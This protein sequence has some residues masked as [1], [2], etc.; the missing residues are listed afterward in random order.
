MARHTDRSVRSSKANNRRRVARSRGASASPAARISTSVRALVAAAGLVGAIAIAGLAAWLLSAPATADSATPRARSVAASPSAATPQPASRPT[1]QATSQ[2]TRS[3]TQPAAPTPTQTPTQTPTPARTQTPAQPKPAP[4]APAQ[5]QQAFIDPTTGQLRPAEHDDFAALQAPAG[6]RRLA[7]TLAEPQQFDLPGGGVGLV[8]PDETM[9]F[10]VASKT[11]DGQVVIEHA[12][13]PT[14]AK[15]LV[16]TRT[17]KKANGH[18]KE[19][20][21]DR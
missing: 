8:T 13:G 11:A 17:A 16:R 18:G 4:S 1:P 19:E 9:A 6:A 20:R 5:A 12:T 21:N 7:R 10:T 14:Q 3:S 15:A 2:P